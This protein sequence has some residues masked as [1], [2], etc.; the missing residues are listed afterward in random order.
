MLKGVLFLLL[1]INIKDVIHGDNHFVNE[2]AVEIPGGIQQATQVARAHGYEIVKEL[3]PF[4]HHYLL[5]HKDVPSR[6]RRSAYHHTKRLSSDS[7]V[8][9]VDQQ[10]SRSR[11]KRDFMSERSTER[12]Y[13]EFHVN[14]PLWSS[15]WYVHDTRE[16]G[17]SIPKLD[18]H[19]LPVWHSGITGKGVV[20][21]VLDDGLEKNHT[22]IEANYDPYASTDLNDNDNDPQPRYDPTDENKHGTRCTIH[23]TG[24][25][26]AAPL[27]AGIIALLLEK[28][29]ELTW[30][31]VQH[32]VTW[33]AEYS[34]LKQNPGW[35]KNGAGFW[36]SNSFGFGLLNA[37]A[38]VKAADKNTWKTVPE[39]TICY[40]ESDPQ[41]A[42]LPMNLR[43]KQ[44]VEI[45]IKT[46]GCKGQANEINYLEHVQFII[47]M[48]YTKR[49]DLSLNA[50]S[51]S[52]VETM[53]L[54]QRPLDK[55]SAGFQEWTFMSVHSWGE[56]PSGTW[57][58]KFWDAAGQ[59]NAGIIKS[60]KLVLH[61][62]KEQPDHV[63]RAQ[64][65]RIYDENYN[66]V[67]DERA[68]APGD[69]SVERKSSLQ[70]LMAKIRLLTGV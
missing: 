14:D 55:S 16:G 40:V 35:K 33:T 42:N 43:S 50:T 20:I 24:T 64:G 56:H 47:T 15:E 32:L 5:R 29:P 25:S 60:V 37:A 8:L 63:K 1:S 67:K 41:T 23:H 69:D 59:N 66:Q 18:L 68:P 48:D 26:A 28:N 2:W 53:L 58:L 65:H 27:A 9:W 39:K 6:S 51:A 49:G 36:I 44:E 31:D 70:S 52:G 57:K 61:G 7:R 10:I 12:A 46:T 11:R 38:M 22:D 3:K 13:S 19:V 4:D 34:A 17:S 30:R 54:S 62:T 21:T 45:K